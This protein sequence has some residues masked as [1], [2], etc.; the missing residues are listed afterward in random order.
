MAV[1]QAHRAVDRRVLQVE[2][3]G[4]SGSGQAE[5]GDPAVLLGPSRSRAR[6]T[7]ARTVRSGPQ[8]APSAG[9]SSCVTR[10]STG[11]PEA[12]ECHTRVSAGVR[13]LISVREGL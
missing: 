12:K 2:P 5:R 1:A 13:S 4:D 3:L 7:L 6:S 9:S 11:A 10:K 8:D